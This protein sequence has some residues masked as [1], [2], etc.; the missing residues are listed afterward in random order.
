MLIGFMG[1]GKTSVGRELA[2]ML[3]FRFVDTDE[4]VMRVAGGRSIPRIFEEEGEAK[5]RELESGVLELLS[6]VSGLVVATGGG[7]PLSRENRKRMSSIGFV[8]WLDAAREAILQR[9]SGNANRPL[10]RG[11]NVEERVDRML[12]ERREFYKDAADLRVET[13]GLSVA[14][15]AYGVAESVR[16]HLAAQVEG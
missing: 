3:G 12:G 13:N 11:G 8:V 4:E 1:S 10:L 9:V 16:V 5:F 15:V 7:L 2:R 14:D 6:G